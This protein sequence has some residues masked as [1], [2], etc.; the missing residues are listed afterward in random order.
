M[1]ILS[2]KEIRFEAILDTAKKMAVAARTAPKARGNDNLEMAI[3]YGDTINIIAAK[4]KEIGEKSGSGF[5]HRDAGNCL[6]SQVIFLIG[7]RIASGGLK[8]CGMCGYK[9]C[10]DRN[11]SH[12]STP[13]VFNSG[14]L[15]IAIGSAV[16]VAME[17]RVDNRV[18]YTIGQAVL[19]LKLLGEETRIAYG[20]PLCV[21]AKSPFHDRPP[22]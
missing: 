9:N 2:E 10:E 3:V 21:S 20:I 7:T 22:V 8:I 11:S 12:P 18:M 19:E 14:D 1:P 15:G 13:C 16:T 5:F 4:M 6:Q 17:N